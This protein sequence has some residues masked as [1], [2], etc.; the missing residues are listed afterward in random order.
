MSFSLSFSGGGCK[1]AAHAGVLKALDKYHL[2]PVAVS[3]TSAGALIA[4]LYSIGTSPKQLEN[5]C[6]ELE[7]HGNKLIDWNIISIMYSILPSNFLYK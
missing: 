1:A 5:I 3:G 6:S 2:K 7:K 4:A